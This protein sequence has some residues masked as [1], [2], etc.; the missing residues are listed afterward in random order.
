M[1]IADMHTHSS[2]SHDSNCPM[3]EMI[4]SQLKKGTGI[5]AVTDHF[6]VAWDSIKDVITPV[7]NSNKQAIKLKEKYKDNFLLLAGV[8]IS[9]AIGH[10]M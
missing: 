7:V 9:E 10:L 6:D 2:N 8:E 4:A 5:M 1:I 3:E